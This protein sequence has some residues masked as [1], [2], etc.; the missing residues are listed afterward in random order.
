MHRVEPNG[1]LELMTPRS[2][3]EPKSSQMVNQLS[4]P[5]APVRIILNGAFCAFT[6]KVSLDLPEISSPSIN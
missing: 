6:R 4:H 5:S 3:P 1:G 2:R